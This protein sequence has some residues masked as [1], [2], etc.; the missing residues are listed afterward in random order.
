MLVAV[1]L[2]AVVVFYGDAGVGSVGVGVGD[3]RVGVGVGIGVG[4][5]GGTIA[6]DHPV[7]RN[8]KNAVLASKTQ[9]TYVYK[10]CKATRA[11]FG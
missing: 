9:L 6:K 8:I 4:V 5:G 10:I 11:F 3:G 7:K 1:L 2:L